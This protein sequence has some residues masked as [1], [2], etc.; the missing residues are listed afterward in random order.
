MW[1]HTVS[2]HY[3]YWC[4][5]IWILCFIYIKTCLIR[6]CCIYIIITRYTRYIAPRA[7]S[8]L[9][10]TVAQKLSIVAQTLPICPCIGHLPIYSI[11]R[12]CGAL[13][14]IQECPILSLYRWRR[15]P[16]CR[17]VQYFLSPAHTNIYRNKLTKGS[18]SRAGGA[19]K[20]PNRVVRSVC[21]EGPFIPGLALWINL[22]FFQWN[23]PLLLALVK[24]APAL[25]MGNTLVIK[26]A[27][28]TS[29]TAIY[30]AALIKEVTFAEHEWHHY[31]EKCVEVR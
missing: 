9:A 31:H 26:P 22:F 17:R 19:G 10:Q 13:E 5:Q 28:Q 2:I 15:I 1:G 30:L 23:F 20:P 11:H 4:L 7:L 8:C 24:V 6:A 12:G 27:E 16:R 3:F 18:S 25:A 21:I 29:L 14:T